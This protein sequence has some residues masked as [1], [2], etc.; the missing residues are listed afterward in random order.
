MFVPG[1]WNAICDRCGAEYKSAQ[2]RREWTGLRVCCG[3]GTRNCWESRHPQD[4]A[5]GKVDDQSP[6]W[7]RPEPAP[8]FLT[9]RVW[10]DALKQWV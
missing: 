4:F 3:E 2:L 5:K 6:P 8:V 9:T 1:Q 10:D 7:T